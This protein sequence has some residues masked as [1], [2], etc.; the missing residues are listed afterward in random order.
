MARACEQLK[1]HSSDL[2]ANGNWHQL[3]QHERL[4]IMAH[5][6][7]STDGAAYSFLPAWHNKGT[8]VDHAMTSAEAIELCDPRLDWTALQVPIFADVSAEFPG[9]APVIIPDKY[10]NIRSD[11]MQLLGIVSSK[12]R[13][14]QNVDCFRLLDDAVADGSMRF[15]SAFSMHGGKDIAILGILPSQDIDKLS[16]NDELKRY[17]L[18]TNN[19][20]GQRKLNLLQ[21]SVRTVCANTVRLALSLASDEDVISVKH[22]GDLESKMGDVREML[23]IANEEFDKFAETAQALR[24]IK[25]SYSDF[26]HFL[27][28]VVVPSDINDVK[29]VARRQKIADAITVRY[30]TGATNNL[31]DMSGSLWSAFNS[32]TEYADHGRKFKDSDS[33]L[34]STLYG[35]SHDLKTKALEVATEMIGA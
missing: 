5:G 23:G 26:T 6:I 12:Y 1:N 14:S 18:F 34:Q 35:A 2:F 4:R 31:D 8:V 7:T 10:M 33:A 11:N 21:T 9:E 15:E 20:A 13:I 29:S 24:R 22:V 3:S 17:I 27:D 32:V 30:T 16:D 19:H 25:L 28:E